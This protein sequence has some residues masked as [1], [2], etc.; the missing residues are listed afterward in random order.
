MNHPQLF[1]DA[2]TGQ[3]TPAIGDGFHIFKGGRLFLAGTLSPQSLCKVLAFLDADCETCPPELKCEPKCERH[4]FCRPNP[5]N[6]SDSIC[7]HCGERYL[8]CH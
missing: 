7:C 2:L 8:N 3:P 6:A 1:P 4:C 5:L